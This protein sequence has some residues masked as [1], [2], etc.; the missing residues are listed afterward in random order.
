M[1]DFEVDYIGI[2]ANKAG[3]SWVN[4]MLSA[5]PEICTSEPKEIHFFHDSDVF[6]SATHIG[7]FEKGPEWYKRFFRHCQDGKV[8]GEFTPKYLVDEKAPLRIKEM[9]PEVRLILCLRSPVDRAISQY[10]FEK[11]FTKRESRPISQAIREEPMYIENGLYGQGLK[12]YLV[13]FPLSRIHLI[14]F[15]DIKNDP[16]K[17]VRE[18]YAFLGVTEDFIPADLLRKHNAA[19]QSRLKWIVDF[20]SSGERVLTSVGASWMVRW[21]KAVKVNKFIA[22]FN[23]KS[24]T[25]ERPSLS[26]QAWM[27]DQFREDIQFLEGLTGRDLSAWRD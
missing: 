23:T 14:W 11:Y 25:Y 9:F 5:H 17:V 13:F 2:G 6:V 12:R 16:K 4:K 27:L 10:H 8:K 19:K 26:D 18:L 24:I 15:D 22:W 1:R 7:N 3:T 21:L 20:L